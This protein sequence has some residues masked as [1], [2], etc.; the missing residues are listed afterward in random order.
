MIALV[1]G[2][3]GF[4]GR[5]LVQ[6]LVE[7]FGPASVIAFVKDA[8]TPLEAEALQRYRAAGLHL[9][10]GDLVK[11][12][13]AAIAPP[14]VDVVFHLGANIDTDADEE[15]LRVNSAGTAQLLDWLAPVSKGVR[16]V[17]ASSVAVHDRIAEP[18][19]PISESSPFTPRTIYG[20]TKLEGE[21]I[22]QKRAA[23][24]GYSWTILRL[25]T[26]YGPGQKPGGLFDQMMDLASR[27][28]FLGRLAW[29]GRTSIVYV[30]DVVDAMIELS[31]RADAAAEIYCVAA[32][33]P[34][35]GE[36]AQRMGRIVRR[37]VRPIAIPG[38]VLRTVRA[39]AWNRLAERL[40]PRFARLA[41][42]RLSLIVSDGFWFDAS[43]FRRAYSK[44]MKTLE[45]ALP[46][47][48][49][50]QRS[51]AG[52]DAQRERR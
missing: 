23:A 5:R 4:I 9:I 2:P 49:G 46:E 20:R 45:E 13:V 38:P 22:L 17:Y 30:D 15:A 47:T 40:M 8:A 48:M 6:R 11:Q 18:S 32:E 33:S 10:D 36:L 7:R 26:V 44:P 25:P 29:P 27:G 14:K 52:A 35:V 21:A 50:A 37:P 43:K 39:I 19:G 24:A 31:G 42:W 41:F 3:T 28:A 16:I 1:T 12:P 34:T 51:T